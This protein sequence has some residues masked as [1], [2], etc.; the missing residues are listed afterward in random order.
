MT[1]KWSRT[2]KPYVYRQ[3]NKLYVR[4]T[5]PSDVR[6]HFGQSE[7]YRSLRTNDLGVAQH[8]A[9][10]LIH[11]WK[12]E[13]ERLRGGAN[14]LA[15]LLEWRA[16]LAAEKKT[17]QAII[18]AA[19]RERGGSLTLVDYN[20]LGIGNN[21]AGFAD[22]VDRLRDAGKDDKAALALDIV[23]G[24]TIPT[25]LHLNEWIA[26]ITPHVIPRTA[27]QRETHINSL[28]AEFPALPVKKTQ[29]AAWIIRQEQSGRAEA[30]IK[31]LIG[32]CRGYYEYLMRLGH[33]NPDGVN[34]FDS[35]KFSR[36]KKASKQDIR[37]AWALE[38]VAKLFNAS[39][40]TKRKDQNLSD[41]ILLGAFTGA[42]IEELCR[43]RVEHIKS[44]EGVPFIEITD[45]KSRAGLREIPIHKDLVTTVNR[46]I[47]STQDGYL[48][49]QEPITKGERG[50]AIGKRFGRLKTKLGYDRRYVFHSLRKTVSTLLER[51]GLHANQAAQLLGHEKTGESYGTYSA[52]LTVKETIEFINK[53]KY[54]NLVI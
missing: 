27:A 1:K 53:I 31:G 17:D 7:R 10:D 11:T 39:K 49:S 42:R 47:D 37:Q 48:L 50:S 44:S 40:Q 30:T 3:N 54:P 26:S 51:Q 52:G 43:L 16:I 28:A 14:G 46:L 24:S 34:P 12:A 32:S 18:Q 29:V 13:V 35:H 22:Y 36:K 4:Y 41:L 5:I 21:A 23:S 33:L 8:R 45:A 19:E 20:L 2:T 6:H 25:T 9:A 38:D 15:D